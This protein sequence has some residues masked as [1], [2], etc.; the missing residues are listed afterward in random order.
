MNNSKKI[1]SI[2]EIIWPSLAAGSVDGIIGI[3]FKQ[4]FEKYKKQGG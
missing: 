1:L 2:C 4:K 3:L